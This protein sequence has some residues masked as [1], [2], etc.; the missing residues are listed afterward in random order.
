MVEEIQVDQVEKPSIRGY[1]EIQGGCEGSPELKQ[2]ED[3][4]TNRNVESNQHTEAVLVSCGLQMIICMPSKS[5]NR[6]LIFLSGI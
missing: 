1:W 4:F 3:T 2:T 6:L 5:G